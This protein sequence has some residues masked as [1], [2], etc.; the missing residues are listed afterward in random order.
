ME[1]E[2]AA[3]EAEEVAVAEVA[4]SDSTEDA[5]GKETGGLEEMWETA[6]DSDYHYAPPQK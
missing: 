5:P 6:V 2:K 3:V 4:E 1:A